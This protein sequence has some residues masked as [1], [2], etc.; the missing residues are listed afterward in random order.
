MDVDA[1]SFL[2]LFCDG[3]SVNQHGTSSESVD[4]HSQ[5]TKSLSGNKKFP[6]VG[7]SVN[8]KAGPASV[9]LR[10]IGSRITF[11]SA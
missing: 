6:E 2:K 9:R 5:H 8:Y 10:R 7:S 4:C 3:A 11:L 1:R